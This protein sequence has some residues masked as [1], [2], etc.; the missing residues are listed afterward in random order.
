[1]RAVVQRVSR[2]SVEV[3]G[4][5][6]AEIGVGFLALIGVGRDDMDS[7]CALIANKIAGLRIFNDAAGDMNL[8]LADVGG[9]VLA[10]SQFTLHG[11]ARKGR[12]PSFIDAAPGDVAAPL[13]DR[14]VTLLRRE[15]ITVA[16][17]EFGAQ[18]RVTLVNEGPVTVLLDSRKLF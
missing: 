16:T 2:A 15:G 11:D 6:I 1:M 9:E 4:Q 3:N 14:V 8:S 18:M 7:D 12:R 5:V 10:V 17:G 13:F